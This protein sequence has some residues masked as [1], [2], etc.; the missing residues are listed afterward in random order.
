M[1][2]KNKLRV[3]VVPFAPRYSDRK[4]FSVQLRRRRFESEGK[5]VGN[6]IAGKR[7]FISR[8]MSVPRTTKIRR[9]LDIA[10]RYARFTDRIATSRFDGIG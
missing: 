8:R 4:P 5:Y 10:K 1:Y 2:T 7:C 9:R 3:D 6:D